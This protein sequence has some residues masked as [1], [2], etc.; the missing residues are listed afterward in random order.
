[1][2]LFVVA[3]A[4]ALMAGSAQAQTT[5]CMMMGQTWSCQTQPGFTPSQGPVNYGAI[6]NHP[7][8]QAPEGAALMQ[9]IQRG[10]AL[11][12]ARQEAEAAQ[13]AENERVA[14][15]NQQKVIGNLILHGE[16]DQAKNFALAIGDISE[17]ETVTRICVQ[18]TGR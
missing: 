7:V 14:H 5:N 1:M 12:A 9:G 10:L 18:G 4:M 6:L 15:A 3:A 2:R 17:A 16:C 8:P 11:R 13:D